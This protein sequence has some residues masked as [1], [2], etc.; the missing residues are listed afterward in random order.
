MMKGGSQEKGNN[1][2]WD[3][4]FKF[5]SWQSECHRIMVAL[6]ILEFDFLLS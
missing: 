4:A 2:A 1:D 5:L 3:I 6:N